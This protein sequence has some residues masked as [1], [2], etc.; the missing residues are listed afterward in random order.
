MNRSRTQKDES[1][2]AQIVS[3]ANGAVTVDAET[4]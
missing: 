4:V 3:I 2:I 1:I